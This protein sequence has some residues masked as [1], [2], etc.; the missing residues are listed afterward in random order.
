MVI[1]SVKFLEAPLLPQA[2]PQKPDPM[3]NS[4]HIQLQHEAVEDVQTGTQIIVDR[5]IAIFLLGQQVRTATL[6]QETIA[7]LLPPT[8]GQ[9]KTSDRPHAPPITITRLSARTH[10]AAGRTLARA[11]QQLAP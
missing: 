4:G 3:D 9:H 10:A 1:S 7:A 8:G 2:G 6:N 11:Q 5:S